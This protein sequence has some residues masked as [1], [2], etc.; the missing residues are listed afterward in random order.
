MTEMQAAEM[1]PEDMS[2]QDMQPEDMEPEDMQTHFPLGDNMLREEDRE[3]ERCV[4]RFIW[5]MW[6]AVAILLAFNSGRLVTYVNGF[7]VGP[8]QD[9]V[10]SL[11]AGWNE[12]MKNAGATRLSVYLQAHVEWLRDLSWDEVEAR[13][14]K[15]RAR[16]AAQFLRG[17]LG[18]PELEARA[19]HPGRS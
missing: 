15:A 3:T 19:F 6:I 8:V 13:A 16:E 11:A 2:P 10:V 18:D 17:M 12:H 5:A 14:Q 9:A 1:E 4:S 7:D